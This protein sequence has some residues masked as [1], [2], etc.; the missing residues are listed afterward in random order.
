MAYDPEADAPTNTTAMRL[1]SAEVASGEVT[2]AVRASVT[3]AGPVAEGDWMG[4]ARSDEIVAVAPELVVAATA[5][6]EHLVTHDSELVTVLTGAGAAERTTAAIE[7]WIAE[8]RPD[9]EVEVHAGGQPLYPYL[10]GV[11]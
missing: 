5:L 10:F 2:Q 8:H 9:V 7:A 3:E 11:E 6:L 1:A 4:I